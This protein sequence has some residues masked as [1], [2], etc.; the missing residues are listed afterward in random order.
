MADI[1]LQGMGG[2][3]LPGLVEAVRSLRLGRS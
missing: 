3:V 1:F 2:G